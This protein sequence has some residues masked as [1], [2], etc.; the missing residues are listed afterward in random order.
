VTLLRR[1]FFNLVRSPG[2]TLAVVAILAVSMGLALTMFEVHGAT[3]NQLGTISGQIGTDITVRPAGSSGFESGSGTLAQTDVDKLS[4]LAHVVSVQSSTTTT[5]TGTALTAAMPTNLP[6]NVNATSISGQP[7]PTGGL[8]FRLRI[9]VVGLDPADTSPT[10]QGGGTISV[11]SGAYFTTDDTNANV[12][13]IGQ[14]L[15]TANNLQVGSSVDIEGTAVQVI[16]IY[17][18]GQLFGDNM[19][20]M[21]IASVQHL[22][23][24]DGVTSVTVQADDVSNVDTV[25]TEIRTIFDTS[26]ADVVTATNQFNRIGSSVTNAASSSQTGMIVSFIVAAA[27]ILLAVLLVVRQRVR[28]IGILKAIGA[29]NWRIGIQFGLETLFISLVAAVVGTGLTFI[30]AQ[31][32]ANLFVSTNNSTVGSARFGGGFGAGLGVISGNIGG[33]H[34]VISPEIF[35]V[36]LGIGLVLALIASIVPVWYIARVRPAEV[37]RNE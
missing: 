21:P 34:V 17:S 7:M 26:T 29:S 9:Q 28:E 24:L 14:S 23:S 37:L 35:L 10:L 20:I 4:G 16:G 27:V 5:Y 8:N 25:V 3:A 32:V 31:K 15:A 33:I 36:A 11:A 12:M 18:S 22:F 2:R 19:I 1:S 13:V 30:F 6:G